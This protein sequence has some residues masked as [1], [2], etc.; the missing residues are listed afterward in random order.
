MRTYNKFIVTALAVGLTL[1]AAAPARAA[2]PVISPAGA[3][4]VISADIE[5]LVDGAFPDYEDA[6]L[7]R[8]LG[9]AARELAART[10]SVTVR[11][12]IGIERLLGLTPSTTGATEVDTATANYRVNAATGRVFAILKNDTYQ[13]MAADRFA[14]IES[15]VQAAGTAFLGSLGLPEDERMKVTFRR[16]LAQSLD[17]TSTG[18]SDG[19]P[20][21]VRRGVTFVSRGY[22]GFPIEGSEARVSSFTGARVDQ[23]ALRW[24]KFVAHRSAVTVALDAQ[25]NIKRAIVDKVKRAALAGDPLSLQMGVVFQRVRTTAGSDVY[26][27]AMKVVVT[28]QPKLVSLTSGRILTESGTVFYANMLASPPTDILTADASDPNMS[29]AP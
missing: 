9:S 18:S 1:S 6:V 4:S 2:T 3:S 17:A 21:L 22:A 28:P 12:T 7:A 20:V 27:P 26:I 5:A 13:G 8:R 19:S 11:D 25:A 10:D 24:P 23:F 29:T 16:V 14:A 15:R